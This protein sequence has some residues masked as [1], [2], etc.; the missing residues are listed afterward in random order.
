M[1]LY[2]FLTVRLSIIRSLFFVHSALVYVIQVC[3]QLSSRTR[4]CSKAVCK[5]VW[6]IPLMSVQW[7]NTSWW[8]GELS[9][10]CRV[11]CQN[12]FVKFVHPGGFIKKEIYYYARSRE[13]KKWYNFNIVF[14]KGVNIIYRVSQKERSIFLEVKVSVILSKKSLYEH[15]SYSERFPRYSH[16]TA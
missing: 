9:E 16:L 6:H 3:G 14:L 4:F 8:T 15:V 1:K 12:K 7:I 11:L 13:H 2:K 10:T 5:P